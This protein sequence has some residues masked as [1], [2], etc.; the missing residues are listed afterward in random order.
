MFGKL[1]CFLL[2]SNELK[3]CELNKQNSTKVY[4][5]CCLFVDV[6]I[7]VDD[8]RTNMHHKE[9]QMRKR[10][11]FYDS[12]CKWLRVCRAFFRVAVN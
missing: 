9:W 7:V 12:F 1:C 6:V 3:C 2:F 11:E 8:V 4:C 5:C 10:A